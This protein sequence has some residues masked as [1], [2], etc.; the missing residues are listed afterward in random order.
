MKRQHSLQAYVITRLRTEKD[1]YHY[2]FLCQSYL[3]CLG[4]GCKSV[5]EV[6]TFQS[7]E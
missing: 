2:G 3:L 1:D 5:A 6:G 7:P 4:S